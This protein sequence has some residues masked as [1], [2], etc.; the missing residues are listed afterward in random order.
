MKILNSQMQAWFSCPAD[1]D[2]YKKQDPE[3]L[4]IIALHDGD[5][6]DHGW[7]RAGTA[8]ITVDFLPDAEMTRDTLASLEGAMAIVRADSARKLAKLQEMVANLLCLEAPTP[9]KDDI[10]F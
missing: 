2:R 5:M 6:A 7:V 10:P 4:P 8:N 9:R 1:F 3:D